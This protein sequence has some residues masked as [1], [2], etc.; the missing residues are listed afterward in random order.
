[1][2]PEAHHQVLHYKGGPSL[3][4]QIELS[5]CGEHSSLL[6]QRCKLLQMFYGT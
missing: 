3:K 5:D 2:V 1:M 6:T 4:C